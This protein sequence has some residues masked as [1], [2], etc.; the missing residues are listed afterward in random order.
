MASFS[1]VGVRSGGGGLLVGDCAGSA[2]AVSAVSGAGERS[3]RPELLR[4]GEALPGL[5]RWEAAL[6]RL[7]LGFLRMGGESTVSLHVVVFPWLAFGH[8]IPYL[9]LSEHLAKRGHFV[10]FISAPR[11][12]AKLRPILLEL[13]PRIRL[14]PL[15]LPPVD[16]LP[17]GAESTADVPPEKVE[18]LKIAFDGLA[19]PFAAFLAAAC[20]GEDIITGEEGHGHAKKPDW[21][22]LDFAHHWLPPIAGEHEVACAVFFIFPAASVAF[23]GPKE[24]NDAHPRSSPAD[25]T[26]PPPWIPSPSCLAFRG[27]EAEWIAQAW[28][29][30]A[31]G[32]SDLGRTWEVV[33]RCLSS[34]EVDGQLVPLLAE[35]YGKPVLP[36]GLLAPYAAAALASS[37]TGAGD[38]DDEET[39]SLMRWLDAQ[40]ERSVLYVAFGSEAPLTPEHVAALARGLELAVAGGVRFVWALRKAIGEETP[41]LPDG[42]ERRVA[43]RGV[44]RVGW[45]P[46]V[47]VLAHA[48]VG[49]FMM[50]AGMS[51]LMESFLFGHP[52]VMLPLFADQGLT[53]RLMAERRVGLE[54]PWRGGGGGEL[55]GEDVARTVRRVMVEEE[56]EV[57]ARNAKE[58]QEVLWDTARQERYVDELVEHLRRL[59]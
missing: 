19:A 25:F 36:S 57:F 50:H 46:Q 34:H 13:K 32:V 55:A 47:R 38:D 4:R 10:T 51:S 53:A 11:N 2:S 52:F 44:V 20:S 33:Q 35:L 48:A 56:R 59:R 37:A 21:I 30:N 40:P 45:V 29:P 26:V 18:L 31:S 39:V 6:S 43:G 1:S 15:S 8:I 42:F 54:V 7:L 17:A 14:L 9:E 22:L 23:M 16:G 24:L 5:L 58:L 27:H 41:P 3:G 28:K 49:G 12:L